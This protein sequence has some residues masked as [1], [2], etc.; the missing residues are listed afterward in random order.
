MVSMVVPPPPGEL[1][2]YGW[3]GAP[4]SMC[5]VVNS[6]MSVPS[7]YF[8]TARTVRPAWRTGKR[9]TERKSEPETQCEVFLIIKA[10]YNYTLATKVLKRRIL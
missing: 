5:S 9:A 7:R 10:H 6:V 3:V 1:E 2:G 8:W 4:P